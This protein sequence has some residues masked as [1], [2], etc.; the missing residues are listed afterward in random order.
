MNSTTHS[1]KTA[2]IVV[3]DFYEEIA[4]ALLDSCSEV[5][6][7]AG[8]HYEV[9]T[10]PGALEIPAAIMRLAAFH[11]PPYHCYVALGCVIRGETYHFEVVANTCAAGLMQA[12]VQDGLAIGNGV[13]TVE[14]RAQALARTDKGGAAAQAAL[15]LAALPPQH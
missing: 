11:K 14:N 2:A 5:L 9:H 7:D 3:A 10:V 6:R 8:V 12:Q 13:L 1:G 15:A 4:K